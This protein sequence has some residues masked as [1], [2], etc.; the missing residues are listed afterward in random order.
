[1][2]PQ[3]EPLAALRKFWLQTLNIL[4]RPPIKQ[5]FR[6]QEVPLQEIHWP[7]ILGL[8]ASEFM[9]MSKSSLHP[10]ISAAIIMESAII[11]SKIDPETLEPGKWRIPTGE[12]AEPISRLRK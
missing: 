4:T 3:L 2:A 9:R 11:T 1:V 8:V 12:A 6:R 10:R 7:I 5:L